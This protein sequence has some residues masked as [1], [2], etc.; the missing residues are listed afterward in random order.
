MLMEEE[1]MKFLDHG[2]GCCNKVNYADDF[3]F[4]PITQQE[5]CSHTIISYFE[6][7]IVLVL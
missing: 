2:F 4:L 6:V 5:I 3:F 1:S 7:L